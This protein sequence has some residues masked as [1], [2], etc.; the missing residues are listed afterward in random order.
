MGCGGPKKVMSPNAGTD[1]AL[2]LT[3]EPAANLFCGTP[4]S[5]LQGSGLSVGDIALG[6]ADDLG[7]NLPCTCITCLRIGMPKQRLIVEPCRFAGCQDPNCY[8]NASYW[9]YLY[10]GKDNSK[11][12]YRCL[13]GA[14]AA[15]FHDF[16][17]LRR[18]YTVK[19]CKKPQRFPWPLLWCKYSRDNGFKRKDKLKS[20]HNNVHKNRVAP[21]QPLRPIMPAVG[22]GHRWGLGSMGARKLRVQNLGWSRCWT[23]FLLVKLWRGDIG[24]KDE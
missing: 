8:E 21:G 17:D 1:Q 2:A 12:N 19:H 3:D 15:T 24:Q 4:E 23:W 10:P 22:D 11:H 9:H 20:H 7:A 13:E 14:C 18:H 6:Y 5:T 16:A